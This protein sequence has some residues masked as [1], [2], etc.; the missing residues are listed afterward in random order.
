MRNSTSDSE[1]PMAWNCGKLSEANLARIKADF[2]AERKGFS[3]VDGID[4]GRENNC[5]PGTWCDYGGG[6]WDSIENEGKI[7]ALK[8]SALNQTLQN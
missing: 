4:K 7:R 8:K 2:W 6:S 5:R 1:S 3:K